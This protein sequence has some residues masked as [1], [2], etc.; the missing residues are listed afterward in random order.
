MFN[1]YLYGEGGKCLSSHKCEGVVQC[2]D[3]DHV[4]RR[5]NNYGKYE[6]IKPC[7]RRVGREEGI[8]CSWQLNIFMLV[9]ELAVAIVL[10]YAHYVQH[11]IPLYL[12]LHLTT[13]MLLNRKCPHQLHLNAIDEHLLFGST[14]LLIRALT[15][16]RSPQEHSKERGV[17]PSS[18]IATKQKYRH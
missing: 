12:A 17:S 10:Y 3:S 4:Q 6:I 11:M 9:M 15:I 13:I 18:F 7:Y 8:L 2:P 5:R 16:F 14:C 1:K